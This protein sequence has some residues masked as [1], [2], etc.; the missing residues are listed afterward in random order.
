MSLRGDCPYESRSQPYVQHARFIHDQKVTGQ[1][2][3]V[4]HRE[5]SVRGVEFQQTVYGLSEMRGAFAILRAARPVGAAKSIF[6]FFALR[7]ETS[8]LR[9]GRFTRAGSTRK[10]GNFGGQRLADAS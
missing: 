10:D 1:R 8:A 2:I 3:A 5:P 7:I 4:I 9:N 6:V